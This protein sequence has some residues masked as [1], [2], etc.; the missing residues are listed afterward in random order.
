M[1]KV[2]TRSKIIIP[3]ADV[4]FG[5]AAA[6]GG[7]TTTTTTDSSQGEDDLLTAVNVSVE[8]T[9]DVLEAGLLRNVQRL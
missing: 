2:R 4:D 7:I 6:E 1:S 8:D 9:E 5:L 3:L